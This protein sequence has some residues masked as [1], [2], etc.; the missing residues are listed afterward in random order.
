[1]LL[2]GAYLGRQDIIDL[3]LD[4]TD[5]CH[6]TYNSTASGLN[7]LAFAW[8][9]PGNA[10]S[11]SKYN[12][13][14][15]MAL[16]A[17]ACFEQ[18]GFF[19]TVEIHTLFPE[20]VESMMYAYRITGDSVWQEYNWEIFQATQRAGRRAGVKMSSLWNVSQPLGGDQLDC[21]PR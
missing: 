11:N 15:T 19:P 20:P 3:G 6:R 16:Q 21:L 5:S 17:R 7:P 18:N 4:L 8:Y 14:S 10:A 1:L 13:D 12:G 2:G 9:G